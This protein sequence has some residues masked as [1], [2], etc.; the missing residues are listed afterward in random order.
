MVNGSLDHK[1]TLK[2]NL[3]SMKYQNICL[4][5]LGTILPLSCLLLALFSLGCSEESSAEMTPDTKVPD[6]DTTNVVDIKHL[7]EDPLFIGFI[8][9]L[10]LFE[11]TPQDIDSMTAVVLVSKYPELNDTEKSLLAAS[12]GFD[13]YEAMVQYTFDVLK[14]VGKLEEKYRLSEVDKEILDEIYDEVYY[15]VLYDHLSN[16]GKTGR[17]GSLSRLEVDAQDRQYCLEESHGCTRA[18]CLGDMD[19]TLFQEM[20]RYPGCQLRLDGAD[21][22]GDDAAFAAAC[23]SSRV[24]DFRRRWKG[25][26]MLFWCCVFQNCDYASDEISDYIEERCNLIG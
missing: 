26:D 21:I 17:R 24:I 18:A 7:A 8:Q 4:F 25:C 3:I 1:Q 23:P 13:T 2:N 10:L 11:Q 14:M 19:P 6:T 20:R 5:L 22:V 15:D 16:A 12:I 9:K